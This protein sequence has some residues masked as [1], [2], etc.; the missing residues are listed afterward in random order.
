MKNGSAIRAS[1][2]TKKYG[3]LVAVNAIDLEVAQGEIFGLLGP[4]GAGKT[5][6]L[7]MLSTMLPPTSGKAEVNGFDV[8]EESGKVRESIGMV[9]Q[10]PS[11]DLDLT[12]IENLDFHGKLYE[13]PAE[14]RRKRAKEVLELVG[15]SDKAKVLVKT[16]SGGMKR[17]LEIA[18]GLMHTPKVLFLDEPTLGLDPQTRRR[19]WDYVKKLSET[20]GLTVII[21]THY[22]EEADSLCGRVAIIDAGK[23]VA[24]DS[25]EKLKKKAGSETIQVTSSDNGKLLKL[26]KKAK[27][28][29]ANGSVFFQVKDG[30]REMPRIVLGAQKNGIEI[31]SIELHGST[32]EDVFIRLTGHRMREEELDSKDQANHRMRQWRKSR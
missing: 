2:L 3:N 19:I 13:M 24:L 1:K 31:K 16:F 18:R 4:N 20:E 25:P 26:C 6:T 14:E 7:S 27:C 8:A 21:T 15:L 23:I 22:M 32:L 5:T 12:A 28:Y 29:Q 10:D 11:L 30:S 17:R 9:F